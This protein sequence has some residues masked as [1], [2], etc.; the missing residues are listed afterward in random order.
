MRPSLS[1]CLA[2]LLS[3]L[4]SMRAEAQDRVAYVITNVH[5]QARLW[6]L[7]KDW[8]PVIEDGSLALSPGSSIRASELLAI[9]PKRDSDTVG[10]HAVRTTLDFTNDR[11]GE[12]LFW[13]PD[14]HARLEDFPL[15]GGF[16]ILDDR[17][18]IKEGA[19]RSH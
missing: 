7:P 11:R 6:M 3:G 9:R 18:W 14:V 4:C 8:R 13:V 1:L 5:G 17:T 15:V 19:S 16:R 2:L 10:Y 12:Q